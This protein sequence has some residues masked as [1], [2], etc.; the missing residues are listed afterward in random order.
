MSNFRDKVLYE[1]YHKFQGL[2]F[3]LPQNEGNN[4]FMLICTITNDSLAAYQ[5]SSILTRG[6]I[7][8]EELPYQTFLLNTQ[9]GQKQYVSRP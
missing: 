3:K 1:E 9:A 8:S 6:T 5:V 2:Y 4:I 7:L